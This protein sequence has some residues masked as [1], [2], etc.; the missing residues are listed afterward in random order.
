MF[1]KDSGKTVD[2]IVYNNIVFTALDIFFVYLDYRRQIYVGCIYYSLGSL[3]LFLYLNRSVG[4]A[5]GH[6]G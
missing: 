1:S 6:S 3:K 2:F 5:S 4:N